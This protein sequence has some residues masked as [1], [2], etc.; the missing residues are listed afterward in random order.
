M[1]IAIG[2]AKVRAQRIRSLVINGMTGQPAAGA[3]V[4]LVPQTMAPHLIMPNA[5][6]DKSGA[7]NTMMTTPTHRLYLSVRPL[8]TLSPLCAC[9]TNSLY[10]PPSFVTDFLFTSRQFSAFRLHRNLKKAPHRG[11][12]L[13]PVI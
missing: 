11:A 13:C 9:S 7:F 3:H 12:C 10:I 1:D 6:A 8:Q 4:R 2:D 5:N